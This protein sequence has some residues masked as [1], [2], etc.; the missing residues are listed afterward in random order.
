M[1]KLT[2]DSQLNACLCLFNE[3][4]YKKLIEF[5]IKD[6]I[7]QSFKGR[8]VY[9]PCKY[10]LV[11]GCKI[12]EY[13]S[14]DPGNHPEIV[15]NTEKNAFVFLEQVKNKTDAVFEVNDVVGY[16]SYDF[17]VFLYKIKEIDYKK[18][19]YIIDNNVGLVAIDF[20]EEKSFISLR[21]YRAA[22]KNLLNKIGF[23][24]PRGEFEFKLYE[25]TKRYIIGRFNFANDIYLCKWDI[26]TGELREFENITGSL[27]LELDTKNLN[28]IN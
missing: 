26:S 21:E 23:A 18:R 20:G 16:S 15:L 14:K 25:I 17:P 27:K 6:E 5:G 22:G 8:E 1:E 7:F 4:N 12:N 3:E 9:A 13:K 10:I 2:K 11:S 19:K 28:L 24:F